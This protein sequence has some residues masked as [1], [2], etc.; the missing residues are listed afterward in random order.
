MENVYVVACDQY[1]AQAIEAGVRSAARALG[2]TLP[3]G[4]D[5]LLHAACPW[6][7]PRFAPASHTHPAV[8]EGVARALSGAATTLVANSVPDFPA[9]YSIKHAGYEA[10][11]RRLGARLIPLDEAATTSVNLGSSSVLNGSVALP[12]EWTGA[13]FT[14]SM[15][16]LTGSTYLAF[17]GAARHLHSLLPHAQ[18]IENHHRLPEKLADLLPAVSPQLIVVDAIEATHKGGELSGE[19]VHLGVLIVGT[20]PVAVDLVCAALYGWEAE[21]VDFLDLAAQRGLGP[22]GLDGV[23]LVGDLRL[24]ELRARASRIQRVDPNPERHPL[25]DQIQVIRSDKARQAGVSGSLTEMFL[26]LERAGIPLK[27]AR[28]T[29]FVIGGVS[30][31]PPGKSG[32]ATIVFLDDTSHGDYAGYSRVIRLQGRN[33]PFSR[34]LMQIPYA[35]ALV[36]LRAELGGAF[37]V[38]GLMAGA[39]RLAR[40]LLVRARIQ[41]RQ[42]GV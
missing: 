35:M 6:A 33:V 29:T 25:P 16:K 24:V 11:A 37:A 30:K 8:I 15:P 23:A 4:G 42:S 36:N 26:T 5:A 39:T 21:Q 3:R 20:H 18:Q 10:L 40:G 41:R 19:P 32:S 27:R 17:A 31:I 2:V 14:V 9:R 38:A 7:H 28:E 13:S 22:A 1:D 34:V 12:T